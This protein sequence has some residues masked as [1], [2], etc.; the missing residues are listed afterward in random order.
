MCISPLPESR[1]YHPLDYCRKRIR[2]TIVPN[3]KMKNKKYNTV[4]YSDNRRKRY[5]TANPNTH[6]YITA[7]YSSK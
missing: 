5:K 7:H 6:V 4:F 1:D 2:Y 3:T